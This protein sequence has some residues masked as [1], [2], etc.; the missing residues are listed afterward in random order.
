MSYVDQNLMS[1]ESVIYRTRLHWII[2]LAPMVVLGF[3]II[4]GLNLA[5]TDAGVESR[6]LDALGLLGVLSL[7]VTI[8][9][10][11]S[12]EFAVTN[13]RVILKEGF[14]RRRSIEILLTKVEAI[15][16]DQSMLGRFLDY[17]SLTVGGSGGTREIFLNIWSPLTFRLKVQQ[18]A[19][20]ATD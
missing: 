13:K 1:G 19:S 8:A 20:A 12:A 4:I 11:F 14:L 18:E 5:V 9:M 10:F 15:G 7:L 16:V 17:G 2:F 6:A 3:F